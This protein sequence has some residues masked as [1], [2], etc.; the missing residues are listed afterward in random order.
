M[1]ENIGTK[2]PQTMSDYDVEKLWLGEGT[3]IN[4]FRF[5]SES[6]KIDYSSM[7]RGVNSLYKVSNMLKEVKN[8]IPEYNPYIPLE[9]FKDEYEDK[10]DEVKGTSVRRVG[11]PLGIPASDKQKEAVSKAAKAYQAKI[12]EGLLEEQR[13]G[14]PN[15]GA[16]EFLNAAKISY[17]KKVLLQFVKKERKKWIE[18]LGG[19]ENLSSIEMGM[20]D[21]A[22]RILLFTSMIN[23]YLLNDKENEILF[24]DD[25]TGEIKMSSAISRNYL[26]FS[27]TYINILKEL[28]KSI[29]ERKSAKGTLKTDAASKIQNLYSR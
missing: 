2:T 27:K 26:T 9:D 20:L 11:R 18:E 14:A 15:K 29:N 5:D 13:E 10:K 6:T 21:E 4:S 24:R 7:D 25:D 1:D 12:K 17:K 3:K 8:S 23:A 16:Y 22:A 19:E 28:Q